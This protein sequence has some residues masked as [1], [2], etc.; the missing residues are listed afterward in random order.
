MWYNICVKIKTNHY[1]NH[2]AKQG[3]LPVFFVDFLD[4]CDPVLAFDELMEEAKGINDKLFSDA[5]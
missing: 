1:K 5:Y 2:T 4:I 3:R